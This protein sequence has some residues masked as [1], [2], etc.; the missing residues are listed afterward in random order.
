[1]GL[2]GTNG[3]RG[4]LGRDL[5]LKDVHDITMSIAA[6]AKSGPVL[7]GR[8]GRDT[9]AP[10]FSMVCSSLCYAGI[11]CAETGI[12]PTPCLALAVRELGYS[13]GI[14]VTASHNPAEY[15]GLKVIWNDG[16]EA[17][18]KDELEIEKIHADGSWG[19]KQPWGKIGQ[20][21]RAKDVYS[22]RILG[23][24]DSQKT[25]N[26]GLSVVIDIGNG[27]QSTTA[28]LVAD[29]ICK[30]VFC[31]NENID[32]KFSGRGPEPKPDN[33]SELSKAV[34]SKGADVGVAFDGDGDRCIMCDERGHILNGDTSAL[35]LVNHLLE[36]HPGSDIVTPINSSDSIE[37]L[38]GRT[39]SN[40]VRTRIGSVVVSRTM[41]DLGALAGYEENGGF[42]YGPYLPVRDG[43]MTMALVLEAI[44]HNAKSLSSMISTLPKSF[45]SKTRLEC[46]PESARHL[47]D[48]LASLYPDSDRTDGI[49]VR[50]GPHKWVM[51]RPSGTEPIVRVYAE[52]DSNASLETLLSE[53]LSIMRRYLK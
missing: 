36:S 28:K 23:N 4:V 19:Y 32:P 15:G 2:F 53:Y 31:I 11:D 13:C 37:E 20:E 41:A 46:T 47:I 50:L 48:S 51:A 26:A 12:V 10:I 21:L 3:V 42:M 5:S 17:S 7:V 39:R 14:M 8:D 30:S 6:H 44:A 45:T 52:S 16:I 18:R 40:I 25:M 38:A 22:K 33:L 1:M 34:L 43:A 27:A 49:K 24:I 35:L 9:S 29:K